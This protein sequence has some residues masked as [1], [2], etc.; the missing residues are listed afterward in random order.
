MD[1]IL[2]AKSCQLPAALSLIK[3]ICT[4]LDVRKRKNIPTDL[5]KVTKISHDK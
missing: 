5:K 4:Y 2:Y 3:V 1:Y